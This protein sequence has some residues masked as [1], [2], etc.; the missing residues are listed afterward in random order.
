MKAGG[1]LEV[2][3]ESRLSTPPKKAALR[4]AERVKVDGK[5]I[6]KREIGRFEK[7]E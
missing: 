6:R 7:A 4:A 3:P 1:L 2:H 5:I